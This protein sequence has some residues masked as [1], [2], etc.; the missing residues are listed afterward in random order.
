MDGHPQAEGCF[1][2]PIFPVQSLLIWGHSYEL[3]WMKQIFEALVKQ[4][5]YKGRFLL[6]STH[7]ISR[8]PHCMTQYPWQH[9]HGSS[10]PVTEEASREPNSNPS[11][12]SRRAECW[13]STG[14]GGA[15]REENRDNQS[16]ESPSEIKGQRCPTA[17]SGRE[18]GQRH[19][20]P[21]RRGPPDGDGALPAPWGLL[22][23][24]I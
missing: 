15:M 14:G 5:I 24:P 22:S 8:K 6:K 17:S 23:S 21:P 7:S 20:Q 2:Q 11:A 4:E 10:W 13:A 1:E 9:H 19:P 12:G 18:R 3:Q 16:E